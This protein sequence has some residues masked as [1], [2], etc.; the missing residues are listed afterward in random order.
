[1]PVF[2][3]G[4]SWDAFQD[5]EREVDRLLN[6]VNFAFSGIRIGNQFPAVN[7]YELKNE[8]LLTSELPG[9]KAEDLEITISNG[10][11][12]IKG[13]RTEPNG[14]P[15]DRYRR[16][17]RFHG[18][19]QRTLSIPDRVREEAL[20]ADFVDGILRIR[21]PKGEQEQARRIAVAEGSD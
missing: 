15:E 13:R 19:W 14:V 5:L 17:E 9:T 20:T 21:L 8:Y 2:R 6:S 4:H 7:L 16:Q 3:W 1:M 12:N 10:L 18:S 11:L